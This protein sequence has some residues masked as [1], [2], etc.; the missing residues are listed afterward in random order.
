MI[1]EIELQY[2]FAD[3][4]PQI[5]NPFF[6]FY[7][8]YNCWQNI[9]HYISYLSHH[10]YKILSIMW[11]S[12]LSWGCTEYQCIEN[13]HVLGTFLWC[14]MSIMS[15]ITSNWTVV[16]QLVYVDSKQNVKALH[17]WSFVRGTTSNR[18]FPS[19]RD[20]NVVII[21]MSWIHQRLFVASP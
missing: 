6:I 18:W 19:Q 4:L 3:A 7:K 17:Y 14:H 8:W 5:C 10:K 16:Q 12:V 11:L 1:S 2:R 15:Q 9:K 20:S 21:S 13:C